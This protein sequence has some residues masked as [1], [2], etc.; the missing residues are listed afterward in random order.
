MYGN[1]VT[2]LP[3]SFNVDLTSY[4]DTS[5]MVYS[6]FGYTSNSVI[7]SSVT[8]PSVSWSSDYNKVVYSQ[9]SGSLSKADCMA[10]F[11]IVPSDDI[12]IWDDG[13]IDVNL[14]FGSSRFNSTYNRPN[15]AIVVVSSVEYQN[16]LLQAYF[17]DLWLEY[18][19][20]YGF[21]KTYIDENPSFFYGYQIL[22]SDSGNFTFNVSSVIP[23]GVRTLYISVFMLNDRG[24]FNLF[25]WQNCS[26][27]VTGSNLAKIN[28]YNN[29]I[30]FNETEISQNEVIISQNDDAQTTRKSILSSIKN[31]YYNIVGRGQEGDSNYIPS[32]W[33]RFK[34]MLKS[35]FVP[36]D[37]EMDE[38]K[39]KFSSLADE[40]LGVVY[41]APNLIG[42]IFDIFQN[43]EVVE[44]NRDELPVLKFPAF[45]I[46]LSKFDWIDSEEVLIIIPDNTGE[47]SYLV[48]LTFGSENQVYF[49]VLWSVVR[50]V[51]DAGLLFSTILICE[52]YYKKFTDS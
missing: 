16:Y 52:K 43:V 26:C 48:D 3:S 10:L 15:H 30:D 24:G 9:A 45:S 8:F 32:L 17:A 11:N 23:K 42:D 37:E 13:T 47:G 19:S 21:V 28:E 51:L 27:N 38:I 44:H 50:T 35:L 22:D 49:I 46:D 29:N 25:Y 33:Q 34:D 39:N 31:I 6:G 20:N 12:D 14:T 1:A 18:G 36:S 41:Q 40:H 4:N 7:D 5:K 2:K